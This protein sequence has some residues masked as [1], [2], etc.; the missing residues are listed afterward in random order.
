VESREEIHPAW[1][2]LNSPHRPASATTN[3]RRHGNEVM[4]IQNVLLPPVLSV[5][6][7]IHHLQHNITILKFAVAR[8]MV[9]LGLSN[10]FTM[11][12]TV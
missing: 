12:V 10:A 2:G 1:L 4:N 6:L 7:V 11:H 3:V 8:P 5:C 9:R